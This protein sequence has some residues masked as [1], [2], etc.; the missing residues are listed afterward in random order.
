MKVISSHY[1]IDK[2]L[3]KEYCLDT[4]RKYSEI[5]Y[6]YYMPPSLHVILI[7]GHRMTEIMSLPIGMMSEEAQECQNK[8]IKK[9]RENLSLKISR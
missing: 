6:W 7:H 8:C 5:Y 3:F 4:A 1:E 2:K 9:F